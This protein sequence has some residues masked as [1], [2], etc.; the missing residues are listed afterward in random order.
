MPLLANM[1]ITQSDNKNFWTDEQVKA[2]LLERY[3]DKSE[4][5]LIA[6]KKAYPNKKDADALYVDT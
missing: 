2:K 6:F 3:G 5:I 1:A 4:A